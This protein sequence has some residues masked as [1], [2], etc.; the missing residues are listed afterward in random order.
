MQENKYGKEKDSMLTHNTLF[1]ID[2]S[3]FSTDLDLFPQDEH[4]YFGARNHVFT[5]NKYTIKL[6]FDNQLPEAIRSIT[7]FEFFILLITT[8]HTII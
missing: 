7:T 6:F 3:L 5:T 4:I 8:A 1:H 2:T